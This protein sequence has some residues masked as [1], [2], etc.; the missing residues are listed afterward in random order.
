MSNSA[1]T[2]LIGDFLSTRD[3]DRALRMGGDVRRICEE[4]I[5]P[6]MSE[7][8]RKLGQTNDPM[9]LAYAV[10]YALDVSTHEWALQLKKKKEK[11]G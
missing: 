2:V 7:I 10:V 4:I 1:R 3:V 5:K 8:D 6:Q 11:E 9:Y